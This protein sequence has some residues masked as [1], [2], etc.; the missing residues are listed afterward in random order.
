M[1]KANFDVEQAIQRNVE[2]NPG[3]CI[4]KSWELFKAQ[5]SQVFV[6]TLLVT[7]ASW[8]VGAVPYFGFFLSGAIHGVLY[9]GL[10]IFFLKLIRKQKVEIADAF[11]GFSPIFPQLLLAGG[12]VSILTLLVVGILAMPFFIAVIPSI[13]FMAHH[14]GEGAWPIFPGALAVIGLVVGALAGM[15]LAMLWIFAV[16]LVADKKMDF[17]PAMELSRKVVMRRFWSVAGLVIASGV[18]AFIGILG[19]G[20]GILF[21]LPIAFGAIAFAY[22][23]LFG[24]LAKPA[25]S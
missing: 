13:V 7:V 12:V 18:I 14:H 11:S 8:M 3:E 9:G 2:L 22:E 16:P 5:F 6:A 21:T 25:A 23:T 1:D 20:V 19:C 15:T 17:W 10:Y 4:A 24:N